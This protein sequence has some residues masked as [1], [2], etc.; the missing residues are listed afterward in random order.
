MANI[1]SFESSLKNILKRIERSNEI[2]A[3]N[4]SELI[5]FYHQCVADGLT[6]GRICKILYTLFKISAVL[7]KPFRGFKA[8]YSSRC[9]R[10]REG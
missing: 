5:K 7:K 9:G 8:R 10:S 3:E 2:C 6:K 1:H 4:R